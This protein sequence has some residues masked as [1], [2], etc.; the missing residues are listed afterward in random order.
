MLTISLLVGS[1]T[2]NAQAA[3]E[4]MAARLTQRGFSVVLIRDGRL[5]EEAGPW[6]IC[7]STTGSGDIPDTIWPFYQ[8]LT[9][10][11]YLPEQS[12][13]VLALGDSAYAHFAQAGR[14]IYSALIDCAAKPLADIYCI[15]AIYETNPSACALEW[16]ETWIDK[17]HA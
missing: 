12:F 5:P 17:L 1:V 10:G 4:A 16:L 13:A 3:A 11:L 7:T 6:L 8:R 2:G 14:D 15:D 9:K